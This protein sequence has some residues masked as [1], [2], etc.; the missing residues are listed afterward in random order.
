MTSLLEYSLK[1]DE[2]AEWKA[3]CSEID[4]LT[5]RKKLL[6]RRAEARRQRGPSN[7]EITRLRAAMIA[8]HPDKGG[9]EEAFIAAN[10]L[11]RQAIAESRWARR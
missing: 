8:A 3:I 4:R 9:N 2:L 10:R 5:R 1:P 11:Y 6:E 7:R